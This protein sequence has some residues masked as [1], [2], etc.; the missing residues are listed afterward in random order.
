MPVCCKSWNF[1]L[2]YVHLLVFNHMT[3][4]I[5]FAAIERLCNIEDFVLGKIKTGSTGKSVE[6][7]EPCPIITPQPTPNLLLDHSTLESSRVKMENVWC[8][9]DEFPTT[10]NPRVC[11]LYCSTRFMAFIENPTAIRWFIPLRQDKKEELSITGE[12]PEESTRE[13]LPRETLPVASSTGVTYSVY[14]GEGIFCS[15]FCTHMHLNSRKMPQEN[16]N[17]QLKL[18]DLMYKDLYG[19]KPPVITTPVVKDHIEDYGGYISRF[20]YKVHAFKYEGK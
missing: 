4:N 8:T 16:T 13:T 18:L 3:T 17:R 14:S 19:C 9:I 15:Y 7:T 5:P 12:T 11:C 2:L 6:S 1:S 20:K 10:D